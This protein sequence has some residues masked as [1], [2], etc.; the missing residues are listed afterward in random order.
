MFLVSIS[1]VE[2]QTIDLKYPMVSKT[3]AID[4]FEIVAK[5][6]IYNNTSSK[7]TLRWIRIKKNITGGWEAATCDNQ[8]CWFPEIDSSEFVIEAGDSA[9]LDV[10]FYPDG[11]EGGVDVDLLVYR[12]KDGREN[13]VVISYE[14]HSVISSIDNLLSEG[15]LSIYPNPVDDVLNIESNDLNLTNIFLIDN[16]GQKLKFNSSKMNISDLASGLINVELFTSE[17]VYHYKIVKD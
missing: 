5:N 14:G 16:K 15:K 10:Y 8:V 13:G 7:D 17:G 11:S 12:P 1:F 9:N 6:Y 2:A 4:A 3:G